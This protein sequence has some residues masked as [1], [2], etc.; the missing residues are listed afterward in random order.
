MTMDS[1]VGRLMNTNKNPPK[2]SRVELSIGNSIWKNNAIIVKYL[3][4][5]VWGISAFLS[6]ATGTFV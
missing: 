2:R 1:G 3:E 6:A 4:T 5:D